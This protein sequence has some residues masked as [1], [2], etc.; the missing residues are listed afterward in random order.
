MGRTGLSAKERHKPGS[1][2]AIEAAGRDLSCVA[3]FLR[4]AMIPSRLASLVFLPLLLPV[5]SACDQIA[6]LDGSKA[7]EADAV[8]VGGACR[9]AGRALEDCFAV[10][11]DSPKAQVFAGWKEMSDYMRENK[12]EVVAPALVKA[13]AGADARHSAAPK[14]GAAEKGAVEKSGEVR[15]RGLPS[16]SAAAA[17]PLAGLT[18]PANPAPTTISV[19]PVGAKAGAE[20]AAAKR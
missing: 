19:P 7:R 6:V 4:P 20:A 18:N 14:A 15:P 17:D 13:P 12:I 11:P 5:L 16:T 2:R 1:I 3:E 9:H 10:Y 8:A